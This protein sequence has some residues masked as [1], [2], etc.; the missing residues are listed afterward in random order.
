M[1]ENCLKTPLDALENGETSYT[2][3]GS[4]NAG[5]YSRGLDVTKPIYINLSVTDNAAQ[6]N[7]FTMA[8]FDKLTLAQLGYSSGYTTASVRS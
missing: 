5:V 8:F 7:W 6:G 1:D 4:T 3:A 2:F